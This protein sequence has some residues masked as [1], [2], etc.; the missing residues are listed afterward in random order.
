MGEKTS[1]PGQTQ[2]KCY[3]DLAC[4]GRVVMD[5]SRWLWK[6]LSCGPVAKVCPADRSNYFWTRRQRR[7]SEN[8]ICRRYHVVREVM[9]DLEQLDD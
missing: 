2:S 9:A 7:E 4:V 8:G 3:H 5:S 1:R 6:L